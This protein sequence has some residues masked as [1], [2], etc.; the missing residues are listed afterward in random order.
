MSCN[1]YIADMMKIC[2]VL[3]VFVVVPAMAESI[4]MHQE[5]NSQVNFDTGIAAFGLSGTD[6]GAIFNMAKGDITI[7]GTSAFLDNSAEYGG[8]LMNRG[9]ITFADGTKSRFDTNR[10][11]LFGGAIYNAASGKVYNLD[12]TFANNSIFAKTLTGGGAISNVGYIS[13]VAGLFD[14]NSVNVSCPG[15]VCDDSMS[16]AA[17]GGAIYNYWSSGK[18]DNIHADFVDNRAS[19]WIQSIGGAIAN[20]GTIDTITAADKGFV[21][22]SAV[23]AKYSYAGAVYNSETG[24]ITSVNADF[25][26][27]TVRGNS[28]ALGGAIVNRANETQIGVIENVSGVFTNN[29]VAL[30]NGTPGIDNEVFGGAIYN[31]GIIAITNSEFNQ[32]WSA[33]I[34]GAIFNTGAMSV[35]T[36]K[37]T[38][39]FSLIDYGGAVYNTGDGEISKLIADFDGNYVLANTHAIGGAITNIAKIGEISG[40]FENNYVQ[41]TQGDGSA[42]GGAIYTNKAATIDSVHG[43][44]SGNSAIAINMAIGGAIT[45]DGKI[46]EIISENGFDNNSITAERLVYGGALYNSETG[47]LNKLVADFDGNS[48]MGA[49]YA[50]GGALF[51]ADGGLIS[52]MQSDFSNN[53]ISGTVM[54]VGGAIYNAGTIATLTG[55]F[56]DNIVTPESED[57]WVAGGAIY[58]EVTGVI[59]LVG[60]N[61]FSGNRVGDELNDIYND[62]VINILSGETTLA[63]GITGDGILNNSAVLNFGIH[64]ATELTQVDSNIENKSDAVI[65]LNGNVELGIV[66]D[67]YE[68]VINNLGTVNI[69]GGTTTLG[70]G[71][72]N[73]GDIVNDSVLDVLNTIGGTGALTNNSTL[74]VNADIANTI[75]N[76]G[77]LNASGIISMSGITNTGNVNILSGETSIMGDVLGAGTI[78]NNG[79]LNTYGTIENVIANNGGATFNVSGND[80]VLDNISNH[81]NIV[82]AD[83]SSTL[84]ADFDNHG[85]LI[86]QALLNMNAAVGGEIV[87]AADGVIN[88]MG[89]THF[90]DLTNNGV[91]D[92]N[93]GVVSVGAPVTGKGTFNLG[94]DAVL[95]LG[96]SKI[97]QSVFNLDG[98]V[99]VTALNNRSYGMLDGVINAGENAKLE[100]EVNAVGVY[101][102]F[103]SNN[104]ITNI[105]IVV[106]SLFEA[107]ETLNGIVVSTKALDDLIADTG[108]SV[109]T[110]GAIAGL[111]NSDNRTFRQ[112]SVVAQEMLDDG[113][114]D[115]V[116]VEMAKVNPDNKP[117]VHSM[118]ASV[119]NQVL[120]V[121]SGR[122]SG[123]MSVGRA[124]GDTVQESGFWGQGLFNKSKFDN[125]FHGYT[126]GLALG[127]DTVINRVWTLGGGFAYNNTDVHAIGGRTTDIDSK[128]LFTYAQYQPNKW[129]VNATLTYGMAEYSERTTV[130]GH[131]LS[132]TYDV[133]T[134][135]AQLMTG[136]DFASGITTEIGGR[137]LHVAQEEYNNGIATVQ[138][139]NNDFLSGVV[140]LKYSF[141]IEN[142][143]ALKLFPQLRAAA[144]YD[145]ISDESQATVLMPGVDTYQIA[146]TGLSKFGGEF[147]IG[148]TARYHGMEL[149]LMYDLDLHQDYTSQTGMIK[150]RG[151]F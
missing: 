94:Q 45:N 57:A 33:M 37:F 17:K 50:V 114:A 38:G 19:S 48:A 141:A 67:G 140:G 80:I 101:D 9:V 90:A 148:L 4:N 35:D 58:N 53:T 129:Y 135:G 116:E 12:A 47:S 137:Y 92:V 68:W 82:I 34:G 117:V 139:M 73:N 98:T 115:Q 55:N 143:W 44:F 99:Q 85:V 11:S 71:F 88:V 62:G 76:G 127:G 106:G 151:R 32:N 14:G 75:V 123:G 54:A 107:T 66:D 10:A 95:S 149:S 5:F 41:V 133:D 74:N 122:M 46:G 132:G 29:S 93:S 97:S 112:L 56:T 36:S 119:Q 130:F 83:G 145:F 144:T 138:E 136:Y 124:G 77:E 78:T 89:T 21:G 121:V 7:G 61:L 52:E 27:N 63:G 102:I 24:K 8:A 86:N 104:K 120:S 109:E 31:E 60:D 111:V 142:D 105:E 59:N 125:Q 84:G 16:G 1:K 6:G 100:L 30:I 43:D 2:S 25:T 108:L 51:N 69:V 79:V 22:N 126:R 146:G 128:T 23:D 39:N 40:I 64:G 81:G 42:K 70:S 87:N 113:R 147:G 134:Y 131:V 91:I 18:I 28:V 103:G 65:N 110:A 118:A 15:D 20:D 49:E 72:V 13:D 150:F 3:P 26:D 96:M